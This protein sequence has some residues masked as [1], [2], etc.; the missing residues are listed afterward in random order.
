MTRVDAGDAGRPVERYFRRKRFRCR[1]RATLLDPYWDGFVE[2]MEQ[3][4]YQRYTI[5]RTVEI[6]VPFAEY[7]AATMGI[8]DA[9]RLNEEVVERYLMTRCCRE[10]PAC[11]RHMM[12]YLRDRGVLRAD[13]A[14]RGSSGPA[15][16]LEYVSFLR[17]HRG[18]GDRRATLHGVHVRAFLES[19][20]RVGTSKGIRRLTPAAIYSFVAGRADTLSRSGRKFMC[21]A[22]RIFLRF[23]LM[24]G[25][26]T[27]DLVSCVPVIPSFK[28]DR[29]PR[30]IAWEDIQ[31]ILAVVDRSTAVGRRDY[32]MLRARSGDRLP[33]HDCAP[34]VQAVPGPSPRQGAEGAHLS[35]SS[36]HGEADP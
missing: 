35:N 2:T 3:R 11:L 29:L 26:V 5:Y 25:Y 24:R 16:V 31:R 13:P 33:V 12:G 27:R 18:I 1:L 8:R 36:R 28:L 32:A 23:L 22:L 30:G 15:L 9:D 20:G 21:T 19:L 6:V 17:D 10:S 7:A 4:G 34:A 14:L